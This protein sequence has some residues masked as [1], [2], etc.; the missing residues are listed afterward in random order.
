MALTRA[1]KWV[2]KVLTCVIIAGASVALLSCSK[3]EPPVEVAQEADGKETVEMK[4]SPYEMSPMTR[5]D[6]RAATSISSICSHLDVWITDDDDEVTDIHQSSTD[7]GFGT[8][9]VALVERVERQL[10]VSGYLVSALLF[11]F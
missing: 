2:L 9:S 5:A 7:D 1:D 6:T 3:E 8:V 11:C 10:L 4:F